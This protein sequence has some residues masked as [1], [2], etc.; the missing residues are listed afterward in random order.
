MIYIQWPVVRQAARFVRRHG[1]IGHHG[2]S[3][4]GLIHVTSHVLKSCE[5][6]YEQA[7]DFL[8]S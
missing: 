2:G 3:G 1:P 8:D 6:S 7:N 5:G 4:F